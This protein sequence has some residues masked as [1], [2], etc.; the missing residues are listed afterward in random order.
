[1]PFFAPRKWLARNTFE[2]VKVWLECTATQ[3]WT[4]F[5]NRDQLV[6]V[7]RIL[8]DGH[9]IMYDDLMSIDKTISPDFNSTQFRI[10]NYMKIQ[11]LNHFWYTMNNDLARKSDKNHPLVHKRFHPMQV[12]LSEYIEK[13]KCCI[14]T[15]IHHSSRISCL[16][17]LPKIQQKFSVEI[18][19]HLHDVK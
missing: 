6:F 11:R 1:M 3:I 15:I 10:R 4:R 17:D 7:F 12:K 14:P 5:E 13:C 19:K 18:V 2:S 16:R 9:L 8:H